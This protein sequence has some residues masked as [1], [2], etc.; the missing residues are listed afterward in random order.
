MVEIHSADHPMESGWRRREESAPDRGHLRRHGCRPGGPVD[1]GAAVLDG[2]VSAPRGCGDC[3]AQPPRAKSPTCHPGLPRFGQAACGSPGRAVGP[4]RPVHDALTRPRR[5]WRRCRWSCWS[6]V[7]V[8]QH[9][10][11]KASGDCSFAAGDLPAPLPA[12]P[13]ACAAADGRSCPES[14][15]RHRTTIDCRSDSSPTCPG[16]P[17]KGPLRVPQTR[18]CALRAGRPS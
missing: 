1:S 17:G 5:T 3:V 13:S 18:P 8:W 9:E 15:W 2:A 14:C 7:V 10:I 12:G 4:P 16:L 11:A 6:A